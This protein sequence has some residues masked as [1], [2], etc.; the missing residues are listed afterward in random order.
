[1]SYL[2]ERVAYLRGLSEGLD[3]SEQTF[4]EISS[5]FYS[6]LRYA[7]TAAALFSRTF[8]FHSGSWICS[9]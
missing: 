2:G 6:P 3:I 8:I 7:I 9:R 4:P 5:I 1:M